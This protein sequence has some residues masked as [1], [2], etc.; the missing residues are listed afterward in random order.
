LYGVPYVLLRDG[1]ASRSRHIGNQFTLEL[2]WQVHPLV[3]LQLFC[4]YF[5]AGPFLR[6][7][8]AGRDLTFLAPRLA[9][10]F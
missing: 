7:T 3:N 1:N 9:V 2:D 6:E 10:R 8:G 4:T 5:V